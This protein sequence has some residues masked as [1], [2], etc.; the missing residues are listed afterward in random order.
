VKA[1]IISIGTELLLGEITDTNAP[2]LASQLPPLGIDLYWISTVG[3]NLERLPEV[4]RRAWERC[5]IILTTG[6]LGPTEADITRQAIAMLVG[7]EIKIDAILE[8]E[9]RELFARRGITMPLSNLNQAVLIPSARAL[10]NMQGTAPGWWVEKAGRVLVAMPGP[11]HEMQRMWEG[12]VLPMLQE[13]TGAAI[14]F[15]RTL[16]TLGLAE[17]VMNERLR[18]H[19]QAANPT[20]GIYVR[21]DGIHL[22]ITAKA[23]TKAEAQDLVARREMEMRQAIGD[24]YIWGVDSETLPGLVGGLLVSSSLTLATIESCTGGLLA[25]TITDN[26]G[27]SSY[28]KGGLVSYAAEVKAIVGVDRQLLERFGTVSP[29]TADA[30]AQAVRSLMKA[31]IGV[32]ITGVA[33]PTSIEDKPV[34][35]VYIAVSGPKP[36][37]FY[38]CLPGN[39]EQIKHRATVTALNEL[40]KALL[41]ETAY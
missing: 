41:E 10:H 5:D 33:G 24:D 22:R 34:G 19:L 16:K 7:E 37:M 25:S 27:S 38:H 23:E 8:G 9:V 4:L 31:D 32:G 26:P 13:R 40:R 20:L 15:S 35:T 2:Y 39:R 18:T 6:G 12:E 21:A 29:E 1:E 14:I 17:A 30:L 36:R 3:D 11:P 28:F